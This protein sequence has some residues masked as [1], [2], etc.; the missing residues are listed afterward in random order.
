MEKEP[1]K[2]EVGT[3]FEF[4]NN[5]YKID[6]YTEGGGSVSLMDLTF[7]QKNGYPIFRVEK[8]EE[9][10]KMYEQSPEGKSNEK[11]KKEDPAEIKYQIMQEDIYNA[12]LAGTGVEGGKKRI[13]EM[14]SKYLPKTTAIIFLKKEYGVY[15]GQTLQLSNGSNGSM[16]H[17]SS[18]MKISIFHTDIELKLSWDKIDSVIRE[19]VQ[20]GCYTDRKWNNNSAQQNNDQPGQQQSMLDILSG[21]NATQETTKETVKPEV[22]ITKNQ[23]NG[24]SNKEEYQETIRDIKDNIKIEDYASRLGLT[25]TT[26]GHF[27]STVEHDS[28]RIN[29]D[30]NIYY[31]GS[32]QRGGSIIDFVMEF[33]EYNTVNLAVIHLSEQLNHSGQAQQAR[34]AQKED[35]QK[36]APIKFELPTPKGE[37]KNVFAYLTKTRS[38]HPEIVNRMIKEKYVYQDT[39]NNCVF[40]GYDYDG[41]PSFAML[42]GTNTNSSE[43]FK[44]DVPGNRYDVGMLINR[45]TN[46]LVINETMIDCMS[47]QQILSKQGIDTK[48]YSYLVLGGVGKIEAVEYH[49]KNHTPQIDEITIALDNDNAGRLATQKIQEKLRKIGYTGKVSVTFPVTNDYNNDISKLAVD[50][51]IKQIKIEQPLLQALTTAAFKTIFSDKSKWEQ[52]LKLSSYNYKLSYAKQLLVFEQKP[53]ATYIATAEIWKDLGRKTENNARPIYLLNTRNGSIIYDIFYDIEDT[54]I[55]TKDIFS[56]IVTT[57]SDKEKTQLSEYIAERYS[58]ETDDPQTVLLNYITEHVVINNNYDKPVEEFIKK[59]IQNIIAKKYDSGNGEIKITEGEYQAAC[60]AS[61]SDK[62][63]LLIDINKQSQYIINNLENEINEMRREKDEQRKINIGSSTRSKSGKRRG[64]TAKNK[65]NEKTVRTSKGGIQSPDHVDLR[66]DPQQISERSGREQISRLLPDGSIDT[67]IDPGRQGSEGTIFIDARPNQIDERSLSSSDELEKYRAD[68]QRSTD[69]VFDS[70]EYSNE[71]EDISREYQ[72]PIDGRRFNGTQ[73][74]ITDDIIKKDLKTII[75]AIQNDETH[76]VSKTVYAGDKDAAIA[77]LHEFI[78]KCIIETMNTAM[79]SRYFDSASYK[80]IIDYRMIEYINNQIDAIHNSDL[81]GLANANSNTTDNISVIY[82][83]DNKT[84]LRDRSE[85]DIDKYNYILIDDNI[86]V[87]YEKYPQIG[88]ITAIIDGKFIYGDYFVC[89]QQDDVISVL[90]ERDIDRYTKYISAEIKDMSAILKIKYLNEKNIDFDKLSQY[91]T[92]IISHYRGT[93][94]DSISNEKEPIIAV[95][96]EDKEIKTIIPV[97]NWNEETQLKIFTKDPVS[98]VRVISCKTGQRAEVKEIPAGYKG[99]QA[100][101]GGI[102]TTI[103]IGNKTEIHALDEVNFDV[104]KI[105]RVITDI[106]TLGFYPITGDFVIAGYDDETGEN[107]SLSDEQIDS[108][109]KKYEKPYVINQNDKY[110]IDGNEYKVKEFTD[111]YSMCWL[112]NT[113]IPTDIKKYT[114]EDMYPIVIAKQENEIINPAAQNYHLP[115]E[116]KQ[117]TFD[118][119]RRYKQNI[120]AI[121][122]MKYYE[123]KKELTVTNPEDLQILAGYNGWGGIAPVFEKENRDWLEEHQE[124]KQI[125]TEKEY[126]S[127]SATVLNAHYTPSEVISGIYDIIESKLSINENM[128]ILDPSMGIGKFFQYLPE[129]LQNSQLDGIEIDSISAR[130]SKLLFPNANIHEGGYEEKEILNNTYNIAISNIPF[131][132]YK[133]FDKEY[134]NEDFLIH[135]YF[136]AKSIDKV[137]EGGIIAFITSTGTLDKANLSVRKYLAQRADLVG[138]IRMPNKTFKAT[139]NTAVTSDIIFL[140][141]NTRLT[142]VAETSYPEWVYTA[143]YE[144]NPD[145]PINTYFLDNPEMM[146][147]EFTTTTTQYGL[148]TTLRNDN[149]INIREE[150]AVRGSQI[151]I[152]IERFNSKQLQNVINTNEYDQKETIPFDGSKHIPFTYLINGDQLCYVEDRTVVIIT[153][154]TKNYDR[155]YQMT[156][157]KNTILEIYDLQSGNYGDNELHEL[158]AKLGAQYDKF[159]KKYSYLN[160]SNNVNAI[161]EDCQA[162]LISSLENMVDDKVYEKAAI[163]TEATISSNEQ[164]IPQTALSAL[165]M[166]INYYGHVNLDYIAE[167]YPKS[168][169]EII[170]ELNEE[171]YF[172]PIDEVYYTKDEFLSGDVVT[173]LQKLEGYLAD[174]KNSSDTRALKSL[175]ALQEAQPTK[176]RISDIKYQLGTKWIPLDV[177]Q[178]FM[179][180]MFDVPNYL[181]NSG[182]YFDRTNIYI[183]YDQY[184]KTYTIYNKGSLKTFRTDTEYGTMAMN[185]FM[186][187]QNALNQTPSKV[188]DTVIDNEGNKHQVVNL[189]ETALA[190]AKQELL[191]NEFKNWVARTPGMEERLESIYNKD[192]N[193]YVIRKF[194]GKNLI[195]PMMNK[196]IQLRDHQL[197]A[198]KRILLNGNTLL[199]HEVGTGKTWT[200]A[201]GAMLLKNAGISKKPMF[202][203]PNNLVQQWAREYMQLFPRA[204]ILV[205]TE[206]DFEKE[207]R[208]RFISKIAS[209][210]YDAIFLGNTQFE[211]IPMSNEY[212]KNELKEEIDELRD[213]LSETSSRYDQQSPTYKNQQ[214][215]LKTLE[216]NLKKVTDSVRKGQ[217]TTITFEKLGVDYLFVDEAHYYKNCYIRTKHGNISGINTTGANKTFDFLMKIKYIQSLQGQGKGI[218]FATGTPITNSMSEIYT[219]QRYLQYHILQKSNIS[220]FDEWVSTFADISS[221]IELKPTGTGYRT[222]IRFNKFY[223]LP[224]LL[225]MFNMVT[226]FQKI[227]NLGIDRPDIIGGK[228]SVIAVPANEYIKTKMAEFEKRADLIADRKVSPEIDNMLKITSEGRALAIDPTLLDPDYQT[229]K[230]SKVYAACQNIIQ[231][232]HE[233]TQNKALQIVFL[234]YGVKLYDTVREE[235]ILAGIPENEI[236]VI[237]DYDKPEK[238]KILFE[239]CKK[240]QVRILL[241]STAKMGVGMNVQQRMVAIHHID[242]PWRPSDLEQRDGRGL[243]QGNMFD[244]IGIYRYVTSGTFDAYM[245]QT[246]EK[247]QTFIAQIMA[248][249]LTIREYEDIDEFVLQCAEVKAIC[250]DNPL[251]KEKAEVDTAISRLLM[252]KQNYQQEQAI[253]KDAIKTSPDKIKITEKLIQNIKKDIQTLQENKLKDDEFKITLYGKTYTKRRDAA[254]ILKAITESLKPKDTMSERST[255]AVIGEYRGIELRCVNISGLLGYIRSQVIQ[256]KGHTIKGITYEDTDLGDILKLEHLADKYQEDL[257]KQIDIKEQTE[258]EMEYAHTQ[259]N[260]PFAKESE[261]ITLLD[262]QAFINTSL[263]LDKE[264]KDIIL[265]DGEDYTQEVQRHTNNREELNI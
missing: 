43:A 33:T 4:N 172:D 101:I 77:A 175:E 81:E 113:S 9:V 55:D 139:A 120:A 160:I 97:A 181:K 62:L 174:E 91:K 110:F 182:D 241:G 20:L 128:R 180:E 129:R 56:E 253:Y 171:V 118:A 210:N 147:G 211:K 103:L 248:N 158:Q 126:E 164:I 69:N 15:G 36:A 196:S 202:V 223:N 179:Y 66:T 79:Y 213:L 173:K 224:E 109:L 46:K 261:L 19:L 186:I 23:N 117:N 73:F 209:G 41:E 159:V 145:L 27:F 165:A 1:T 95:Y 140:Q 256:M 16:D 84:S 31:R 74:V 136:F 229:D 134:A 264:S 104:D 214:R 215:Q 265:D 88:D 35:K 212:M 44:M 208:K 220:A 25:L 170:E 50:D 18:G 42:R 49:L 92:V 30:K 87:Y 38:L 48:E 32:S 260:K 231:T 152:D 122:V 262:R 29:P 233:T 191:K 106:P 93:Y 133:I 154:D 8:Y 51:Y 148:K 40:V 135:D 217:D 194:D 189:K 259:I 156:E 163:F 57:I 237:G 45:E 162:P 249:N 116:E 70:S 141:K 167:V 130:I 199:A 155:I 153:P 190:S 47:Y 144:D 227:E 178:Q 34:P 230:D 52:F 250:C 221:S 24:Y 96:D 242:A 123:D 204:N 234:D 111:T 203:V 251:I 258:K 124:L 90:S 226:D 28:L 68:Q 5:L 184:S 53:D 2:L 146:V 102:Y 119:K 183:H 60:N 137:K 166:S 67:T 100:E 257:Q 239:K 235:F 10:L 121:K 64:V 169:S 187:M 85:I 176:I 240:G 98:M 39:R 222:K 82:R 89:K 246:L 115:L 218:V 138:A 150:I 216:A 112:Q 157:I 245:W 65:N 149:D 247:K 161:K 76:T 132:N 78:P 83:S 3:E 75:S 232:Y 37:N 201:A 177:Y 127:A 238:K 7:F 11:E 58:Y 12:V 99:T 142:P 54:Y 26:K 108:C 151:N 86:A 254:D 125:L 105:N 236:A 114:Y 14:Y 252:E 200:M 193:R 228:P 21:T 63:N 205:P 17:D 143:L 197:N 198:A 188:Y 185:G 61:N 192:M 168:Q 13:L 71:D 219:M 72:R 255:E 22:K 107:I 195:I 243:R 207:N 225:T 80:E 263:E 6:T 206:K 94:I 244:K 59:S 131:G